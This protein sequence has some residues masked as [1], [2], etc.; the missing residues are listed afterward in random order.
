MFRTQPSGGVWA[1]SHPLTTSWFTF[2][3]TLLCS[4]S[5]C[6]VW[7]SFARP[8]NSQ[9]NILHIA[10]ALHVAIHIAMFGT[11]HIALFSTLLPGLSLGRLSTCQMPSRTSRSRPSPE[12]GSLS[13]SLSGCW[14]GRW[15]WTIGD[16]SSWSSCP[17]QLASVH[18]ARRHVIGS[19]EEHVGVVSAR[20]RLVREPLRVVESLQ[21]GVDV[22]VV[23]SWRVA[24]AWEAWGEAM[25]RTRILVRVERIRG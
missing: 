23:A 10:H 13:P 16:P 9:C 25:R 3:T 11:L 17:W 21:R 15:D 7:H 5:H 19:A 22:V 6:T 20:L 2:G 4:S 8:F 14:R 12:I 18:E 24:C 1:G